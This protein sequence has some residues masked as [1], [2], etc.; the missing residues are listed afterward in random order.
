MRKEFLMKPFI[1]S[2][3]MNLLKASTLCEI[4]LKLGIENK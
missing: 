2:I 4:E 1:P 3:N